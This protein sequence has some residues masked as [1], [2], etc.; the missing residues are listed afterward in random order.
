[1]NR[2]SL[3]LA[4]SVRSGSTY[5]AEEIAYRLHNAAQLQ[6]FNLTRDCFWS[7]TSR[8]TAEDVKQIFS[9]LYVDTSGWATSKIHCAS[10]SVIKRESYRDESVREAFFGPTARWIFVRRRN[11]LAQAVSLAAAKKSGAWA[12]YSQPESAAD[13][14]VEISND[15]VHRALGN[16]LLDN[17]FLDTFE[18]SLAP[19]QV[20]RVTYEDIEST[21]GRR[22][23]AA[24]VEACGLDI[25][26]P[27]T[28]DGQVAKI[29]PSSRQR[30]ISIER[31][32]ASWFTARH[33]A[34]PPQPD[35]TEAPPDPVPTEELR[36]LEYENQALRELVD[37]RDAQIE[38]IRTLCAP[39]R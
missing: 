18:R 17:I 37:E 30:K 10:M 32:F 33:F 26:L 23:A 8:S 11:V 12:V 1:L 7:L 5:V 31:E 6:F 9:G 2:N 4:S 38:M 16:I 39:P 3:F 28:D 24:V 36:R 15:E 25:A 14:N 29:V 19:E 22:V 20:I 13:S 35:G 34:K 21:G 27:L